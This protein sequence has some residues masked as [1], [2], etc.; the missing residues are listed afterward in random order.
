MNRT[1]E[2]W[3]LQA[4]LALAQRGIGRPVVDP[5]IEGAR[6]DC[7]E[8]GQ[9][10]WETEELVAEARS[11]SAATAEESPAAEFGLVA[12]YAA[13]LAEHEPLRQP[14]WWRNPSF[15]MVVMA[16]AVSVAI[17]RTYTWF[18]AGDTVFALVIGIP[19]TVGGAVWTVQY[20]RQHQAKTR[21][22]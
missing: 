18:S 19:A 2:S 7:E 6:A 4:R 14:P 8:S 21:T 10:A 22:A 20:W 5:L 12:G 13:E 17:W 16:G 15:L 9:S 11:H 1:F 3:E